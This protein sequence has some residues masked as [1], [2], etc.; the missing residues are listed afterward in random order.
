M[1]L[2]GHLSRDATA[3][4]ARERP[5]QCRRAAATPMPAAQSSLIT[6]EA[7]AAQMPPVPAKKRA[8]GRPRRGEVR[9]PAKISPIQR[10]RQ[11]TL[12]QMIEDIPTGC[13]RGSK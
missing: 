6:E 7:P 3:I 13:D 12:A 9:A 8:R 4:E 5:A 10:Q 11:Q 1:E 2:I